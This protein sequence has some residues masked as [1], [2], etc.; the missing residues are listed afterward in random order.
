MAM[1]KKDVSRLADEA[2]RL[3]DRRQ[4]FITHLREE[5]V[6]GLKREVAILQSAVMELRGEFRT[7]LGKLSR[8]SKMNR[9][10]F[11]SKL[12]DQV[13]RML[14]SF[15]EARTRMAHEEKA[16]LQEYMSGLRKQVLGLRQEIAGEMTQARK[17]LIRLSSDKQG[18]QIMAKEQKSTDSSRLSDAVDRVL[19]K[20]SAKKHSKK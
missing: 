6:P 19:D 14:G 3:R 17:T 7:A 8:S 16:H 10:A 1:I 2:N 11:S 9:I 18:G 15:R 12:Q 5:F 20:G 13:A 4:E